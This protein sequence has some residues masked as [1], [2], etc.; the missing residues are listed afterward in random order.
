MA[1]LIL[2]NGDNYIVEETVEEI[3][4]V[5][6]AAAPSPWITVTTDDGAITFNSFI[7]VRIQNIEGAA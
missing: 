6:A 7:L 4:G 5:I 2:A 3:L 1:K